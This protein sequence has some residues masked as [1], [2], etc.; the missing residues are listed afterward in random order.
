MV[1]ERKSRS[2]PSHVRK[3]GLRS[4]QV[5]ALHLDLADCD[6]VDFDPVPMPPGDYEVL[7]IDSRLRQS[8]GCAIPAQA[9][10]AVVEFEFAVLGPVCRGV[11][12]RDSFYLFDEAS[13][14]RLKS[15]VLAALCPVPDFLCDTEELHG[16]RC[17]VRVERKGGLRSSGCRNVISGYMRSA[18]RFPVRRRD[19]TGKAAGQNLSES[20][21]NPVGRSPGGS[22]TCNRLWPRI[23]SLSE[24]QASSVPRCPTLT[25]AEFGRYFRSSS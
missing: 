1:Y 24:C 16:L 3:T 2:P 4:S 14:R 25:T 11:R 10:L 19:R 21:A 15:M 7:I 8:S 13:L 9:S 6:P 5:V 12:L 23:T 20:S 22:F 18:S 17:R